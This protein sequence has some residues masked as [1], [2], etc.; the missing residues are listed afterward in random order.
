MKP[1]TISFFIFLI[2]FFMTTGITFS[3]KDSSQVQISRIELTDG[4]VLVGKILS[5]DDVSIRFKT[6]SGTELTIK[7]NQIKKREEVSG[8]MV[9]GELWLND[10]NHSRLLFAPTGRALKSGQG[11][12]SVYEIFFPFI[13]VGVTDF[14]TLAGG[15]SLFPGAESQLLYLAPKIT[16]IQLEKFDL[17]AGV[18]F[19][20]VPEEDEGVGIFYGV[21]TYGN[22]KTS[23]T[24]GLGFAF[25]G[26]EV[27]DKP[28]FALGLEA[29]ASR[30]IKFI[31]E[32]WLIPDSDVQLV[33][34]GLRFF[35]EN[36]AADFAFFYPAGADTE[37]FP[38]LP[39]IGFAYNFG[40]KR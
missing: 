11:Y 31:T 20:K 16:P 10:P 23:F 24:L 26:G 6:Q 3:Q 9:Q 27:A 1:K 18:L 28:V 17:A 5:E 25:A 14:L 29:R 13:A 37:G 35:G 12:F 40:R 19:I 30:S 34:A 15:F 38:F 8:K 21:G 36:L 32:N 7:K 22:E 4:S 33:S 2:F 39:W